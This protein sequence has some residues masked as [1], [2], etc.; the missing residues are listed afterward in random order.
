[1]TEDLLIE[2]RLQAVER[3]LREL[4]DEAEIRRLIASYGPRVDSGDAEGAAGLWESDGVYDVDE[5]FM[6]GRAEIGAMVRS[7]HHQNWIAGGCAHILGP[8]HVLLDG[9]HAVAVCHS[10]MLVKEEER[11]VVRRATANHWTLR[12]GEAGWRVC[13]RTSR[14]LDGGPEGPDLLRAGLTLTH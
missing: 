6:Q 10:L 2:Q 1:M 11:F 5:L 3:R 4:E 12:R 9:D 14:A 13:R 8:A 7:R